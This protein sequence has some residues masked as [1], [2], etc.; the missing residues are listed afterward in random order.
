MDFLY[1]N[2]ILQ[3]PV[4]QRV[5]NAIQWINDKRT[6]FTICWIVIYL[7]DKSYLLFEQPGLGGHTDSLITPS[8]CTEAT[9]GPVEKTLITL[10]MVKLF[11]CLTLNLK[12]SGSNSRPVSK[13]IKS[14]R[15]LFL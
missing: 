15:R 1:S 5:D 13:L 10:R 12:D 4:V 14:N 11:A 7:V 8:L 2:T 9:C 6:K 3:G